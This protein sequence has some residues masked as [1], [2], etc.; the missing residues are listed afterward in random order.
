V[1]WSSSIRTEAMAPSC[2]VTGSL[3]SQQALGA[4][5]T[6]TSTKGGL[7]QGQSFTIDLLWEVKRLGAGTYCPRVGFQWGFHH[8]P[9]PRRGGRGR[10]TPEGGSTLH[11]HSRGAVGKRPPQATWQTCN[12]QADYKCFNSSNVS[13]R[14]WSWNYR[15]CWHQTCP[16]VVAHDCVC[17]ASIP[18]LPVRNQQGCCNSS[19]PHKECFCI[20]QFARLLPTLVVVAI[21]QAPSPESNPDSLL[22]VK[23]TV[24]HYTTVTADRSEVLSDQAFLISAVCPEA[25]RQ[26]S[27]NAGVHEPWFCSCGAGGERHHT[28]EQPDSA[29]E[30]AL[31][32]APVLGFQLSATHHLPAP[33][34]AHGEA[35]TDSGHCWHGEAAGLRFRVLATRF[36]R[37]SKGDPQST[38]SQGDEGTTNHTLSLG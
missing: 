8:R 34:P 20:G 38:L 18:F 31:S 28:Q 19:L 21:S 32:G 16:P 14:L 9:K 33:G 29:W 4:L 25:V 3:L 1:G 15:G 26:R 24:V 7:Q 11:T 35:G 36:L 30:A 37:M 10:H 5:T 13:I 23:A 22:P 27:A 6:L 12:P 2:L 17:I